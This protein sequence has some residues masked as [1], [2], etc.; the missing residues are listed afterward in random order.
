MGEMYLVRID[1]HLAFISPATHRNASMDAVQVVSEKV[2][3]V[4]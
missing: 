3:L 2:E 4:A 1:G